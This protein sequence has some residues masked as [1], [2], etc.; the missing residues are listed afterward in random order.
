MVMYVHIL[1]PTRKGVSILSLNLSWLFGEKNREKKL[2]DVM[3]EQLTQ[4]EDDFKDDFDDFR[5]QLTKMTRLQYKSHQ[6]TQAALKQLNEEIR[7]IG[8]MTIENKVNSETLCDLLRQREHLVG[9]A[10]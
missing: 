10:S 3:R 6:E 4:F 8:K 1:L 2:D 9:A 5:Q 7:N